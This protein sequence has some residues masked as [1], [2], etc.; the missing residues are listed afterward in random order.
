MFRP[1]GE[2]LA[3]AGQDT[4]TF[5][6]FWQDSTRHLQS[7]RRKAQ[8]T[9][10]KEQDREKARLEER[11]RTLRRVDEL[12]ADAFAGRSSNE[13][14]AREVH[15]LVPDQETKNELF[16]IFKTAIYEKPED[17]AKRKEEIARKKAEIL[18]KEID[19][20]RREKLLKAS[21]A[22]N[23]GISILTEALRAGDADAADYLA[24]AAIYASSFLRSFEAVHRSLLSRV[25]KTKV[26]WPVLATG[27]TGWEKNAARLIAKLGVGDALV[28]LKARFR[29]A[30]GCDENLPARRWAKAAVRMIEETRLRSI[31][32]GFLVRDFGSAHALADFCLE[33]GWD[34]R[35]EAK[36]MERILTLG[37]FTKAS[38]RRWAKV[39]R[40]M[41]REQIP[42]FHLHPDWKNQRNAAKASGR[43]TEGL[44][45]NRILDDICDALKSIAPN[46]SGGTCGNSTAE[47]P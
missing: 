38:E 29:A 44:V 4:A 25:A 33:N 16:E 7:V 34:W 19:L 28:P 30:R 2:N 14:A 47:V 41:V 17:A 1:S 3:V 21:T 24:D 5:Q 18:R 45:Q 36:W 22:I 37:K 20:A 31:R 15:K 27:D 9:R 13:E 32:V 12:I 46:A 26:V 10:E 8:R 35:L 39:I 11:L 42:D 23:K 43:D 6:E 40:G